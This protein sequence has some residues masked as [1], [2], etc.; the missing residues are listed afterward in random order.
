MDLE[1]IRLPN[2]LDKKSAD[3]ICS[4]IKNLN[5]KSILEI[6][7][8]VGYSALRFSQ[9]AKVTTIEE[10]KEKIAMAKENF[11]ENKNIILLEGDAIKLMPELK[12]DYDL[13]F[14]DARKENYSKYFKLSLKLNPKIIIA[15]NTES[16]KERMRDFLEEIKKY[17]AKFI[18]IGKG[19]ALTFH[20]S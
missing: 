19:L 9:F 14:I 10:N 7:T 2:S 13:I 17:N 4:L 12:E 15:D 11:K 18:K 5:L 6:G 16:H 8:S 3:F 1:K 20:N